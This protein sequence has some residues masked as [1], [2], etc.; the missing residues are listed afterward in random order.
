MPLNR[1]DGNL[2]VAG[3]LTVDKFDPPD[4]CVGDQQMDVSDQVDTDKQRHL[5]PKTHGQMDGGSVYEEIVCVHVAL[6]A[7]S[8]EQFQA[9]MRVAATGNSTVT[10]DLKKNGTSILS[11]I[12][13]LDSTVTAYTQVVAGIDSTLQA[14]AIG[15]VFEIVVLAVDGTGTPGQGLFAQVTFN[16]GA[17]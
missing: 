8:V 2:Y 13:D 9:G 6:A 16:E 15:D 10:V 14:Y 3:Q 7:G 12:I 17:F 5:H 11:D 1:I 4:G